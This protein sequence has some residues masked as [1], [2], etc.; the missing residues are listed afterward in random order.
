MP[1][2]SLLSSGLALALCLAGIT[3]AW[4]GT[5]AETAA[6]IEARIAADDLDGAILG[7]RDV[8]GQVWDMTQ[9]IGFSDFLLVEQTASGFG[10]YNPR[11]TDIFKKG[12]PVILY[13]EP[14]GFGYAETDA[15]V[16]SIGFFVDL[17]VMNAAGEVLGDVPGVTELNLTSRLKIREFPANITYNLTG[18]EPGK[19]VLMTTLR[20]KNSV[21][22]G[23]FQTTIEIIE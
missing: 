19:Y 18:L 8:L 11:T 13:A 5:I 12:E 3:Q 7:A 6:D 14:Y 9:E 2:R 15:G 1:A 10:I 16:Y 21:K 23:V 4:A 22:A 20:D 17:R